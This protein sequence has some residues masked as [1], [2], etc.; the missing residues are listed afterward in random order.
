MALNKEDVEAILRQR[1][2]QFVEFKSSLAEQDDA[3][4]TMVAFANSQGGVVLFGVRDDG[5]PVGVSVGA[6]TLENLANAVK[7]HTYPSLPV[8][9][10]APVDYNSKTI[11]VVESP[12]DAPPH[13]GVYLYSAKNIPLGRPVDATTLQAFRRVGRTNQREDFMRL[14]T[15]LPTDPNIVIRLDGAGRRGGRFF[16]EEQGFY[17]SNSGQGWALKVAFYAKHPA[18]ELRTG[19]QD[20]S[21][22]PS[23][24]DDPQ[25]QH[26]A[27]QGT[28]GVLNA[29]NDL[30]STESAVLRAIYEDEHG[31]TWQSLLELVPTREEGPTGWYYFRPGRF[32]RRIITFPPK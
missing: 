4:Q 14:R 8:F 26:R 23:N 12:K 27:R 28:V 29:D 19:P 21:L 31:F 16:P 30:G 3:I 2:G 18:Y 20:I 13:V 17:Y 6:N 24:Q 32:Q 10:G 1:E 11:V 25:Y 9:I 5:T 7:E 15:P 22:P